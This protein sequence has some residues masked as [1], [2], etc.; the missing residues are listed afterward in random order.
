MVTLTVAQDISAIADDKE[1]G[2]AFKQN[3]ISYMHILSSKNNWTLGNYI[4][5]VKYISYKLLGHTDEEAYKHT[6]PK[7]YK[8]FIDRKVPKYQ[9]SRYIASYKHNKL[10]MQIFE[11]TII[12][13]YILNAPLHQEALNVLAEIMKNPKASF[14][15]KVRAAEV[16]L[17]DT[18]LP[19]THKIQLQVT[20]EEVD[21]IKELRK[22]TEDLAKTQLKA[23][24]MGTPLAEIA[25][26][27]IIE[28]E[29]EVVP[30][31]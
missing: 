19:E 20:G 21:A 17:N 2:E 26:Q 13:S 16:I 30:N 10:V 1:V 5:A 8:E 12:P 23:L 29:I 6:F 3:F 31:A 7:K 9:I 24:K 15:A 14:I 25:E 27:N 11:Q 22:A 28:G 4:S 18:R